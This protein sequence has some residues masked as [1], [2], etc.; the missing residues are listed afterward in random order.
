M[1]LKHRAVIFD[2][3]GTLL[4]T[5]QDLA[6]AVNKALDILG[7]PPHT[8]EAIKYFI[9]DG[10]E[11]LVMRALPESHR[12]ER[13]FKKMIDLVNREYEKCWEDHTAPY[14]GIPELL[15]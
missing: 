8:V 1:R 13:T 11:A 10:R 2:L 6:H 9:G 3:D 4:D 15:D 7:Y 14:P 12:D 5:L